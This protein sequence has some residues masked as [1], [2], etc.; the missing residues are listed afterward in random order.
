MFDTNVSGIWFN[1]DKKEFVITEG[2]MDVTHTVMEKL[3][4]DI[5]GLLVKH[6]KEIESFMRPLI[7]FSAS[8]VHY[9][10]TY[11]E[12]TNLSKY[13]KSGT[14]LAQNHDDLM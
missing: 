14:K 12:Y 7:Q 2:H 8:T 4:V 6:V 13:L 10:S 9:N 1:S 11:K 3:G 5:A